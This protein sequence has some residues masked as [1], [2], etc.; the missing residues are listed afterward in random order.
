MRPYLRS[1]ALRS[2][3][4]LSPQ[5]FSVQPQ[6]FLYR[7]ISC[8]RG[9]PGPVPGFSPEEPEGKILSPSRSGQR[10]ILFHPRRSRYY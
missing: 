1:P 4:S 7:R 9:T 5:W 3:P 10:R 8:F 2:V 6:F